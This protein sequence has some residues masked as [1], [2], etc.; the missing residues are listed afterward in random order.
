[1]H[2]FLSLSSVVVAAALAVPMA[3]GT[4]GALAN[5]G[6]QYFA[7]TPVVDTVTGTAANPAPWT[8]SQGDPT[9]GSPYDRSLPTFSRF[10]QGWLARLARTKAAALAMA[11]A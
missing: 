8:L 7:G 9:Y 11:G 6:A 4:A 10:G 2:R 3:F 5:P 1:M